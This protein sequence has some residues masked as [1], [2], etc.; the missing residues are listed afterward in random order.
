MLLHI[1]KRDFQRNKIITTILFVFIMLSALLMATASHVLMELTSSL[2]NLLSLSKAPHFVQ[3][4]AGPIDEK[5]IEDFVKT[6]PLVKEQQTV[7]MLRMDGSN[8]FIGSSEQP[9]ANSVMDIGFVRQSGF[10]RFFIEF[11]ESSY[12]GGPRRD[13]SAYLL[14]A[15]EEPQTW[16]YGP[17]SNRAFQTRVYNC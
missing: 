8:V 12:S 17:H 14:H 2:N 1:V 4:H 10:F 15:A 3:M 6:D 9:E 7:E 11:R 5:G 16:R 13:C